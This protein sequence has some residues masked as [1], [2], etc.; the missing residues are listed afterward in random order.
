MVILLHNRRK[1]TGGQVSP[2]GGGVWADF[3]LSKTVGHV[4]SAQPVDSASSYNSGKPIRC[5]QIAPMPNG[6]LIISADGQGHGYVWGFSAGHSF[7]LEHLDNFYTSRTGSYSSMYSM[8]FNSDGT[9]FYRQ[10]GG[11][12]TLYYQPLGNAYNVSTAGASVTV[13]TGAANGIL[14]VPYYFAF[15]PD[16][17]VFV[18]KSTG[19]NMMYSLLLDNGWPT[20]APNKWMMSSINLSAFD[21]QILSSGSNTWNGFTFSP[22]GRCMIA[23]TN[24]YVVKFVMSTPWDISTMQLHSLKNLTDDIR[25]VSGDSSVSVTLS[26]IAVNPAGTKMIVHN[27]ATIEKCRFFEYNL[28]V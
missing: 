11:S 10:S 7:E 1:Y 4:K 5:F 16:G 24:I 23:T 22:D 18:Y 27:R 21:S 6:S 15:S 3:D 28:V 2:S 13:L 26:G 12:S 25:S 20:S 8:N 19:N 14:S 9:G 17:K